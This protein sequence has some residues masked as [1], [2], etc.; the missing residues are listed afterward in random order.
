MPMPKRLRPTGKWKGPT[1]E[2]SSSGQQCPYPRLAGDSPQGWGPARSGSPWVPKLALPAEAL[3]LNRG[4]FRL[5][6]H[7]RGIA[8]AVGFAKGVAAGNQGDGLLIVHRH[9]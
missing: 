3:I 4:A 9:A 8:S 7:K 2:S 6:P 1:R 5:W